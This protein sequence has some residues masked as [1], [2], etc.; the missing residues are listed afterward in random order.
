MDWISLDDIAK[1]GFP[2]IA[3]AD[4][5]ATKT[6]EKLPGGKGI[7]GIDEYLSNQWAS[8]FRRTPEKQAEWRRQYNIPESQ[9][10]KQEQMQGISQKP[11]E[12]SH[13]YHDRSSDVGDTFFISLALVGLAY[14][15]LKRW[16]R[17]SEKIENV[18]QHNL[19][20]DTHN[21]GVNL[22]QRIELLEQRLKP[23][24]NEQKPPETR[25]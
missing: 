18:T 25:E 11:I 5:K 7:L 1:I 12:P 13:Y 23:E 16:Q 17:L 20:V 9:K 10:E 21:L 22:H 8:L 6:I 14:G 4:E 24:N 19:L 15:A 3:K 2:Y